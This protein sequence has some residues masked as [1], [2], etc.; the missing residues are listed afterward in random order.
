MERLM[1]W[2]DERTAEW[3]ADEYARAGMAM[4]DIEAGVSAV[5]RTSI[6]RRTHGPRERESLPAS[7]ALPPTID[8]YRECAAEGCTALV[9]NGGD[10]QHVQPP[11]CSDA[12]WH[13]H[14]KDG[15]AHESADTKAWA[16]DTNDAIWGRGR[17]KEVNVDPRSV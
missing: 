12:C 4:N 3:M 15:R 9:C 13:A 17:L 14:A 5:L 16:D 1:S 10:R 7:Q 8:I 6:P 11:Y 2:F